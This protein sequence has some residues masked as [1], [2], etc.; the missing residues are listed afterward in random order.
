MLGFKTIALFG[1]L[2]VVILLG[3][4]ILFV[5]MDL[6]YR[7][8]FSTLVLLGKVTLHVIIHRHHWPFFFS[9]RKELLLLKQERENGCIKKCVLSVI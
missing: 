6:S 9:R 1:F 3:K 4:T 7:H 5:H 2:G 8:G